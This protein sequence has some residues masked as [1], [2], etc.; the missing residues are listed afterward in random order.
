MPGLPMNLVQELNVDIVLDAGKYDIL[1]TS[2]IAGDTTNF[3]HDSLHFA[4]GLLAFHST[5]YCKLYN[6]IV[7]K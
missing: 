2:N 1:F 5:F 7:P 6:V 3:Q 4:A